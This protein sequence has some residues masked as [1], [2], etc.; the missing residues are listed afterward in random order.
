MEMS[1]GHHQPVN[2][3]VAGQVNKVVK[4]AHISF[5]NS[6]PRLREREVREKDVQERF[7]L[8]HGEAHANA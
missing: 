8:Y 7:H 1:D 3:A 4:H 6:L 2:R 5:Y